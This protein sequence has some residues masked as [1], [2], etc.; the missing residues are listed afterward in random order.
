[1]YICLY[2]SVCFH[3]NAYDRHVTN[4]KAYLTMILQLYMNTHVYCITYACVLL[5][6]HAHINYSRASHCPNQPW[7]S[8]AALGK[9][10]RKV[11]IQ[12]SS[13]CQFTSCFSRMRRS[14]SST[15]PLSNGTSSWKTVGKSQSQDSGNRRYTSVNSWKKPVPGFR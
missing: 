4:T 2:V 1:M 3:K 11:A 5:Y 13:I 15:S 9:Q 12:D 8:V 14:I 10:M 6:S 7:M